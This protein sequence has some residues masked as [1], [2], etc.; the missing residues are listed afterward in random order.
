MCFSLWCSSDR[1][2]DFGPPGLLTSASGHQR[3]REG[4]LL[5]R[6]E[7]LHDLTQWPPY[8]GWPWPSL[9]GCGGATS[10]TWRLT[11][12]RRR[13]PHP[14]AQPSLAMDS[15][16]SW[17]RRGRKTSGGWVEADVKCTPI[18]SDGTPFFCFFTFPP[19]YPWVDHPPGRTAAAG[20]SHWRS[21]LLTG[22]L[23]SPDMI[24]RERRGWQRSTG[25]SWGPWGTSTTQP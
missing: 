12:C 2:P 3:S 23:L 15:P 19:F 21:R 14:S 5:R 4:N 22:V 18:P 8:L 25:F 17:A 13:P 6:G 7:R 24:W 20:S 11:P 9:A 10:R 16:S 1:S